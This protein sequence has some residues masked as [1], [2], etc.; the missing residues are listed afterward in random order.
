MS[1]PGD[2]IALDKDAGGVS[3][4]ANAGQPVG[5]GERDLRIPRGRHNGQRRHSALRMLTS[6]TFEQPQVRIEA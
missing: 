3:I 4:S 2:G 5:A 1:R 6:V